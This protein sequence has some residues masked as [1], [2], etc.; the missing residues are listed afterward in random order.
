VLDWNAAAK[1]MARYRER[2][3]QEACQTWVQGFPLFYQRQHGRD[4]AE[5]FTRERAQPSVVHANGTMLRCGAR[6]N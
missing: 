5:I 3:S 6:E 2:I 4:A 1:A